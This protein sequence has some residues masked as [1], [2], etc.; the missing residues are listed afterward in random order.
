MTETTPKSKYLPP[1]TPREA[2][3]RSYLLG[4]ARVQHTPTGTSTVHTPP[5]THSHSHLG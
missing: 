4:L 3:P 2:A 1:P 5:R